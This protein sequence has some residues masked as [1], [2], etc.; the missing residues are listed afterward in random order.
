MFDV[1]KGRLISEK[2]FAETNYRRLQETLVYIGNNLINSDGGMYLPI[3]SLIQVNNIITSSNNISSRSVNVKPYV[4][5]KIYM[6]KQLT[7]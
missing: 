2:E 3:D 7:E 1:L 4:F 5:D 6:D